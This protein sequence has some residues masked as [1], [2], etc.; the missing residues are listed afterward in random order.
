[1]FLI[2]MKE[3]GIWSQEMV[4]Q[5]Q[6]VPY[7]NVPLHQFWLFFCFLT[8]EIQYHDGL[9]SRELGQTDYIETI[10]MLIGTYDWNVEAESYRNMLEKKKNTLGS[11]TG[12]FLKQILKNRNSINQGSP[13]PS[14]F[15][16]RAT[17]SGAVKLN[18]KK[19]MIYRHHIFPSIQASSVHIDVFWYNLVRW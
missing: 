18:L 1:M 5:Y 17:A 16:S 9:R 7:Q 8:E 4:P 6:F 19:S 14:R 12:H 15:Q 11:A 3:I 10:K 2:F 13:V